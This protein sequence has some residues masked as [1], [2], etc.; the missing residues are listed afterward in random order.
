MPIF[1]PQPQKK[2]LR[3]ALLLA[4]QYTLSTSFHSFYFLSPLPTNLCPSLFP[5]VSFGLYDM[6]E[7][8]IQIETSILYTKKSNI[9]L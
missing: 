9:S 6:G 2:E 4:Y 1:K 5:S 3:F 8:N 7:W